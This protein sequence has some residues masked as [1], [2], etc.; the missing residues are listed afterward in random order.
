LLGGCI[1]LQFLDL[2]FK[3]HEKSVYD[4]VEKKS[5]WFILSCLLNIGWI[6]SWH[7]ERIW[8]SLLAMTWLFLALSFMYGSLDR[9]SSGQHPKRFT[10]FFLTPVRI[11]F[12]WISI[13]I[14]ANITA[15][16]ASMWVWQSLNA[17]LVLSCILLIIVTIFF[18]YVL[19]YF[20]DYPFAWVGMWA[21]V[22]IL[23]KRLASDPIETYPI[24]LMSI[25]GIV[26][27]TY[28]FGKSRA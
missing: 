17:Q 25:V 8:I 9:Y 12:A 10:L 26:V 22:G 28:F 19:N 23:L 15:V 7:S 6:L 21:I 5:S 11:Y 2:F 13:A 20:H 24:I 3:R 1:V 16:F 18:A 4:F 27:I 14:F